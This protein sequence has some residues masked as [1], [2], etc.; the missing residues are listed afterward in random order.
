[1]GGQARQWKVGVK[2][3]T[4]RETYKGAQ[5]CLDR[6]KRITEEVSSF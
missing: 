2:R 1:M 6:L 5:A 4:L 3:A